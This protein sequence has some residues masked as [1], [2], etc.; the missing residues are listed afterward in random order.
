MEERFTDFVSGCEMG[1]MQ[2]GGGRRNVQYD[3]IFVCQLELGREIIE[4]FFFLLSMGKTRRA[5]EGSRA[6]LER[7]ESVLDPS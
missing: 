5:R 6:H 3:L 1:V 2:P 7:L 4:G